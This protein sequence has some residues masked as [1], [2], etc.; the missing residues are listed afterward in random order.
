MISPK[1]PRFPTVS[2]S[3]QNLKYYTA[4]IQQFGI[5]TIALY[6]QHFLSES[7]KKGKLSHSSFSFKYLT[8]FFFSCRILLSLS[9]FILFFLFLFF[10]F[11]IAKLWYN[12]QRE[13]NVCSALKQRKASDEKGEQEWEGEWQEWR[14]SKKE[15]KGWRKRYEE[16]NTLSSPLRWMS[17]SSDKIKKKKK[18]ELH[19]NS[20]FVCTLCTWWGSGGG[21]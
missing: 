20:S 19:L 17:I 4:T 1:F 15:W 18:R 3:F 11:F 6:A 16:V 9:L 14:D 10:S 7:H 21:M 2:N 8:L 5:F 12:F 13:L